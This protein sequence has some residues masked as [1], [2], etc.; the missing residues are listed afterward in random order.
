MRFAAQRTIALQDNHPSGDTVYMPDIQDRGGS[1]IKALRDWEK[2]R[3]ITFSFRGRFIEPKKKTEK[4]VEEKPKEKLAVSRPIV[5]PR[6][7]KP[8]RTEEEKANLKRQRNKE[9]RDRNKQ[10]HRDRSKRWRSKL[11]PEQK[12]EVARRLREWRAA[13][14]SGAN[15]KDDTSNT[16]VPHGNTALSH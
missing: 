15:K 1:M 8:K 7:K 16:G 11:T 14:K 6:D 12:K 9:Y 3:G 2:R 13:R 10:Q 5:V 4:K